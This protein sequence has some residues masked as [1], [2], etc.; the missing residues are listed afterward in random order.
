MTILYPWTPNCRQIFKV[1][2]G[3]SK[4]LCGCLCIEEPGPTSDDGYR[5]MKHDISFAQLN[6]PC[7]PDFLSTMAAESVRYL[8]LLNHQLGNYSTPNKNRRAGYPLLSKVPGAISK[9]ALMFYLILDT[10]IHGFKW[11]S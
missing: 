5:I 8:S 9:L 4:L 6:S 10:F 1:K 11:V 3:K 2:K 7:S